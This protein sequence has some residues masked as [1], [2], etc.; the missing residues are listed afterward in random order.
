MGA[1]QRGP[2]LSL[3]VQQAANVALHTS[4]L[5]A[6]VP[7]CVLGNAQVTPNRR[8]SSAQATS[9]G[10]ALNRPQLQHSVLRPP[11][12]GDIG[13]LTSGMHV[14]LPV[15]RRPGAV[16]RPMGDRILGSRLT[17]ASHAAT[18]CCDAI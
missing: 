2:G 15:F 4:H 13:T 11:R 6:V 1:R 9:D 7:V 17:P 5:P 8:P 16:S 14:P 3:A 18:A 12:V 10:W